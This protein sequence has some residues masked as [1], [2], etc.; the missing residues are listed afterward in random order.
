MACPGPVALSAQMRRSCFF[1]SNATEQSTERLGFRAFPENFVLGGLTI[2][3]LA[4][5]S[6]TLLSA[7]AP[8]DDSRQ[9]NVNRAAKLRLGA[10]LQCGSTTCQPER[11]LNPIPRRPAYRED[12]R[13]GAYSS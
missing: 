1:V 3:R 4:L 12:R 11:C 6:S 10:F 2:R 7:L 8:V 5:Q 9:P 13:G